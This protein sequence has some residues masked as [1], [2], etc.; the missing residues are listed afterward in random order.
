M[1]FLIGLSKKEC[2]RRSV[3]DT[4]GLLLKVKIYTADIIDRTDSLS[5]LNCNK[6]KTQFNKYIHQQF[7]ACHVH[8]RH[9]RHV[10]GLM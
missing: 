7:L 10:T 3:T 8:L 4:Q 2:K 1:Q 5:N 6:F 9:E